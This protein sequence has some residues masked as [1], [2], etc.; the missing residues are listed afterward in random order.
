MKKKKDYKVWVCAD[1]YDVSGGIAQVVDESNE[2]DNCGTS[3][4]FS[5]N[6][7]PWIQTV[8]GDVHSNTK[9]NT[10]GGPP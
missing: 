3:A 1:S 4:Q 8:G 6:Y 7:T 5:V 10:T 2:G 9:I